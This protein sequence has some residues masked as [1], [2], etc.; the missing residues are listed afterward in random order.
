MDMSRF[1]VAAMAAALAV[2]LGPV[3]ASTTTDFPSVPGNSFD[4][5]AL[6]LRAVGSQ[7]VVETIEDAVRYGGLSLF[8]EGF[9]LDS[10]LGWVYGEDAEGV[11]GELDIVVPLFGEDESAVFVQPGVVFWKGLGEEDRTD[12]NL[13]FVYRANL[14][15][16]FLGIDAVAGASL[17]YDWD[18][19]SIG[20]S[21]IG[22]GA[23]IQSGVF[24][25]AFNY[26]HPLS[27]ETDGQR[28]DYVEEALQGMDVRFV[29]EKDSVR[30]G[31]RLGYWGYDGGKGVEDKSG[32]SVGFDAGIRV[33]PGMFLEGGWERY[34]EEISFEP[35]WNAGLAFRFSLPGFEGASYGDGDMSSNLWKPVERE[36]R[37][38]Y[39]ERLGIARINL[40]AETR[41]A[42]P[43][44]EGASETVVLMAELS[45][46]LEQGVRLNIVVE[47]A[48]TAELG[49]DKD[50]TYGYRVY[51]L[52][53]DT[54]EQLAPEGDATACDRTRCDV[55]IPA[56]VTRFDIEVE[57]LADDATQEVSEFIDFRI[58]V[59]E[60]HAGLLHGGAA[61]RV[62][63][64]GQGNTISINPATSVWLDEDGGTL[65]IVVNVNQPSP[66]P[67]TLNVAGAPSSTARS[68]QYSLPATLEIPANSDTGTIRITGIDNT[69][70][71][72]AFPVV[73]VEIS[74][75]LPLGWEFMDASGTLADSLIHTVTI[76]DDEI[77]SFG[78]D[79]ERDT[80]TVASGVTGQYQIRGT[81][82]QSP[83]EE[84]TFDVEATGTGNSLTSFGGAGCGI[85]GPIS[86]RIPARGGTVTVTVPANVTGEDL[87]VYCIMTFTVHA[88]GESFTLEISDP[89]GSLA[90]Q[91]FLIYRP[92]FTLD[93]IQR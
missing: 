14:A 75:T 17:F 27:G 63:I 85:P 72:T 34:D 65:D 91:G 9:Q 32:F 33:L 79:M 10:S 70:G 11:K 37:I 49:A 22:V 13:G 55:I 5:P 64:D 73:D 84:I 76:I 45:E 16:T 6:D 77:P 23:D 12:G 4:A 46:A 56:G 58:D 88:I 78:W 52:N 82:T 19:L 67:M 31:G 25:G 20:H 35:R 54:G 53:A 26:Y 21:R 28:E 2:S 7:L 24:H 43:E 90:N 83:G 1:A 42:E 44:E 68:G 30:M 74:G 69:D 71:G 81:L 3:P 39:Q 8:G 57:V 50:Y 59:P 87:F 92:R 40:S 41:V 47:E 18:L 80:G 62:I 93:V 38:L 15:N 89:S 86:T 60:E 36:K 66:E 48:T 61:T 51:E 29:F